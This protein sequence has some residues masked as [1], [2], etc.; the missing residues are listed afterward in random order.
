VFERKK[1]RHLIEMIRTLIFQNNVPKIFWSESVLTIVYL[2]NRL[3]DANLFFKSPYEIL[4]GRKINL[5]HL[6]VFG[7]T[8]FDHKNRLFKL[9]FTSIKTISFKIF[10]SKTEI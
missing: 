2:I 5:E 1:T 10:F 6:K 9:D 8:C 7:C 4:Y 3:P